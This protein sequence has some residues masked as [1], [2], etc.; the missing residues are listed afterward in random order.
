MMEYGRVV[1]E[2]CA[3]I[4]VYYENSEFGDAEIGRINFLDGR[5]EYEINKTGAWELPFTREQLEKIFLGIIDAPLRVSRMRSRLL[6]K[7]FRELFPGSL[8][9]LSNLMTQSGPFRLESA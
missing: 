6:P 9:H 2:I 8:E 7:S 3:E 1:P 5:V 4:M